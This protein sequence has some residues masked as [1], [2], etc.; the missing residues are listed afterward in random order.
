M[1]A[2]NVARYS[3]LTMRPDV[4][5]VDILCIGLALIRDARWSFFILPTVD[6]LRAVDIAFPPERLARLGA[7]IASILEDCSDLPDARARLRQF[8]GNLA[9][10]DFEGEIAFE[11]DAQLDQHVRSIMAESVLPAHPALQPNT[12]ASAPRSSRLRSR[13]KSQFAKMGIL[14]KSAD[15]INA[16]KVI[17][18]FP[19]SVRHGLKADFALKNGAMNLTETLDFGVADEGV[20]QKIFEAQAKC[21]VLRTAKESFGKK[22]RC[23]VVVADGGNERAARSIDLLSTVAEVYAI[24]N[25]AD[26]TSYFEV[27]AKAARHT[28]Q[29]A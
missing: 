1:F 4:E 15:E 20:R 29:L 13:L 21:L 14:G 11:N 22:T 9:L 12:I 28:G 10:H 6:K 8:G 27:I 26:M 19:V 17:P 7:N 23:H 5:R 2:M 25:D 18:N 3:L 24:E 16:H